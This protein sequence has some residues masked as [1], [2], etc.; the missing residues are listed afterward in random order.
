MWY[1][2]VLE[3][4]LMVCRCDFCCKNLHGNRWGDGTGPPAS[5]GWMDDVIESARAIESDARDRRTDVVVVV[6]RVGFESRE[7]VTGKS[8]HAV[9]R[10]VLRTDR[11]NDRSVRAS[12]QSHF[13]LKIC[14]ERLRARRNERDVKTRAIPGGLSR[15]DDGAV[16]AERAGDR[17]R[18]RDRRGVD[19]VGE[20]RG[21]F[22]K[23]NRGEERGERG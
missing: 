5:F 14:R 9:K 8:R 17:T 23:L 11:S 2:L 13:F 18:K 21:S 10:A 3:M 1:I 20:R 19:A 16:Y 7:R 4:F 22:S 15:R 12:F 6:V